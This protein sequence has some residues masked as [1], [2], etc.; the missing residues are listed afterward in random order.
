MHRRVFK[1]PEEVLG[2]EHPDTLTSTA[3]LARTWKS[4]SRNGEA[5]SLMEMCF[6]LQKQI[7]GPHHPDTESSLEALNE[8]QM[9][10]MGMGL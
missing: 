5:I 6:Q 7:V 10:K 3:N 1:G 4:Q 8:C 2:K 9:E